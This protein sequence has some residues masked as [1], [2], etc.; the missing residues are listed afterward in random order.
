MY[1]FG[2]ERCSDHLSQTRPQ[3]F[4]GCLPRKKARGKK[5]KKSKNTKKSL[6][7]LAGKRK[8]EHATPGGRSI[9]EQ[10]WPS[11]TGQTGAY[12]L[13][14]RLQWGSRPPRLW[15]RP[16][17]T[18]PSLPAFVSATHAPTDHAEITMGLVLEAR[19]RLA[20]PFGWVEKWKRGQGNIETGLG[21]T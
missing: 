2:T 6:R 4:P 8:V 7:G 17:S 20:A 1:V 15:F 19:Q 12:K 13:Y 14:F 5:Q 18:S 9:V 11:L 3:A 21:S 16:K 10:P